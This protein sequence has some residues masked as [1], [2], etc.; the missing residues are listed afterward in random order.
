MTAWRALSWWGLPGPTR[1]VERVATAVIGTE[2]GVV[3]L[4]LPTPHPGGLIG[5]I[6]NHLEM[7]SAA[8]VI[9]VD[10]STGLRNRAP[11]T[12]LANAAG[13]RTNGIRLVGD[14]LIA[15]ELSAGIFVV[16]GIPAEDWYPWVYFLKLLRTERVRLGRT[17]APSL[18]VVFPSGVPRDDAIAVVGKEFR[19]LGQVTRHDTETF[20]EARLGWPDDSL[21]ARTAVSVATVLAGWDEDLARGLASLSLATLANPLTH[22]KQYAPALKKHPSWSNG[23]VD[24][25]D[26]L[27]WVHTSALLAAQDDDGLD[28]RVWRG[29]VRILFPFL[30]Q[31]R[32][33]FV[34][35]YLDHIQA[36]LP[37]TKEFTGG[38]KKTYKSAWELELYDVNERIKD[39]L[40]DNYALLINLCIR[41]RRSMAHFEPVQANYINKASELWEDLSS[42]FTE[43]C[44]GWEWPRCGQQLV[45]LIGPSGAGKSTW[46]ALHHDPADIVSSDAIR[47]AMTGSHDM[48]GDQEP[49]FERLR[50]IVGARLANGRSAVVDATNLDQKY[51]IE[52]LRNIPPD[53]PVEYVVVDRPMEDKKATGGWRLSKPGLMEI[54][55]AKFAQELPAILVGDNM[56]NIKI[57][58]LRMPPSTIVSS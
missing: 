36:Q 16:E 42:T 54:H 55:A 6:A 23:L 4:S 53:I 21:L 41:M 49:V 45:M 46:A 47:E 43:D 10:A 48:A 20:I 56:T 19:W 11:V 35:K 25:W 15:P 44:P 5:A 28:K 9:R 58:D 31:I 24:R 2:D 3:G 12:M 57:T 50:A 38:H 51:R 18:L 34:G 29:Q 13:L 27:T 22:L 1:F 32:V 39:D 7:H 33:A 8:T 30:D 52:H 37:F 17:L 14:F 40:P 26:G